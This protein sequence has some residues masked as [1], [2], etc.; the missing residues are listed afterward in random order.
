MT[1]EY[2]ISIWQHQKEEFMHD[3]YQRGSDIDLREVWRTKNL[4]G[5]GLIFHDDQDLLFFK[6]KYP[7][8]KKSNNGWRITQNA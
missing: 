1:T 4:I 8:I 6:L 5:Y 3:V 2:T 7:Q